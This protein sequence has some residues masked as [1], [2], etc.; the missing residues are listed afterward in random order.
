MEETLPCHNLGGLGLGFSSEVAS[1]IREKRIVTIPWL[2]GS[3][4]GA[5]A[6]LTCGGGVNGRG[7]YESLKMLGL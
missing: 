5:V 3:L 2:H 6:F 4:A 7:K 1:W